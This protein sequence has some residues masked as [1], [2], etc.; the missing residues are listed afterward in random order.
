MSTNTLWLV[1]YKTIV[2][3]FGNTFLFNYLFTRKAYRLGYWQAGLC[4]LCCQVKKQLSIVLQLG[5]KT[6]M[7]QLSFKILL[8]LCFEC[9]LCFNITMKGQTIVEELSP[10]IQCRQKYQN[11]HI[12]LIKYIPVANVNTLSTNEIKRANFTFYFH[13]IQLEG[14]ILT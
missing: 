14:D 8:Q 2:K 11:W 12:N 3:S 13:P 10:K 7:M 9:H 1:P 4:S 6:V 5:F